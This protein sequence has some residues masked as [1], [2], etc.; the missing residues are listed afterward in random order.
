MSAKSADRRSVRDDT[1]VSGVMMRVLVVTPF[2][3]YAQA[4]NAGPLVMHAHIACLATRHTVTLATF[5]GPDGA[6]LHAIERLRDS[7]IDVH[8]LWR[9]A[10][11]GIH[12]WTR[13]IRLAHYWLHT[14]YPLRNLWFWDPNMQQLL[15]R[16]FARIPFDLIDVEDNAM[17]SYRYPE[18]I[19]AA[20]TEHEVRMP[21]PP[22]Q[23]TQ[24]RMNWL[25]RVL[26]STTEQRRW[27]QYQPNV[28][29]RFDRI[30]VFTCHDAESIRTLAPDLAGRV[31]VNPFGIDIPAEVD[32]SHEEVNTVVFS[33]GFLHPP[34]VDAA[35]WLGNEI[36]P[37]LRTIR[38]G[39][40]L[41]IVGSHPPEAVCALQRDDVIVTGRVPRVE[42]F[43]EQAAVVLAPVRIGGG[44]RLKVLQAMALGKAIVTTPIGARG[45]AVTDDQPP[46]AI[47]SDAAGVA[48]MTAELLANSDMRRMLGRRARAFVAK[49][50]SWTAY[51][52]RLEATYAGI[53]LADS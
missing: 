26:N 27:Q 51:T 45:F 2:L 4:V 14:A 39:V 49:H 16:L 15:D 33:G 8:A 43:L 50:Y 36:M 17:G 41:I 52:D 48:R 47:V 44:L 6:E 53:M 21:A 25:Y 19:P 9:P 23:H 11:C 40:R 42:P 31:R 38:P 46:L 32:P 28:W 1:L 20:L 34:N 30:Q 7:G 5:A 29:R 18:Q 22:G 3:P 37:I 13:R 10:P 35:L 24:W 12:Q